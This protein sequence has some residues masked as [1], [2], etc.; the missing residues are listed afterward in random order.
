MSMETNNKDVLWG[1]PSL[2]SS[3][4]KREYC[5][6][7]VIA[8]LYVGRW[9]PAASVGD[10]W[11]R[12]GET[13][14]TDKQQVGV[15]ERVKPIKHLV[16][17]ARI[18][19]GNVFKNPP[20]FNCETSYESWKNDIA[21]WCK[22]TDIPKEKQALAI[23]LVLTGKARQASSEVEISNLERADGVEQ[24][25]KKL[26]QLFLMDES[27]RQFRAFQELYNLRRSAD[28]DVAEFVNE[29]ERYYYR[30]TQEKMKLPDTVMAFMLLG[31]VP[32]LSLNFSL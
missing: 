13:S 2:Q 3:R 20:N 23:H 22:L 4:E 28:I 25:I 18:M 26:D 27:R 9:R 10:R 14:F 30:F 11:W 5:L 29:F 24:L 7:C 17:E 21:I 31:R 15:V 6:P 12:E 19:A 1:S 32:Y 16:A 8:V